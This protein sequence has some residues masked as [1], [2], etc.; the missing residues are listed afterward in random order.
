MGLGMAKQV[1]KREPQSKPSKD[2]T[3]ASQGKL[4]CLMQI[5]AKG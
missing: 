3:Q 5:L 2:G 1:I 4:R